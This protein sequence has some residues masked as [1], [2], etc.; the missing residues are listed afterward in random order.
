MV[1]LFV[2][3]ALPAQPGQAEI[4]QVQRLIELGEID[5]ALET[6]EGYIAEYPREPKM[7]FLKGLIYTTKLQWQDAIDVFRSLS[8]DFPD[9]PAPLNNLAV[10]Y[11][12]IGNYELALDALKEALQINPDYASAHENLGDI[13]VTL[14]ALSYRKATLHKEKQQTARAKL[15]V[16]GQ[17]IPDLTDG[18]GPARADTETTPQLA[19]VGSQPHVDPDQAQEIDAMIRSWA[20]AW[21]SQD[22]D[23]YLGF[24]SDKFQPEGGES[25]SRWRSDRRLRLTAPEYI[26]VEILKV[27]P[28]SI[29]SRRTRATIVQRYESNTYQGTALKDLVL[30]REGNQWRIVQE[31][32]RR[33]Q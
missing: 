3:P 17:L 12:E 28:R 6:A 11:A 13:Y 26:R 16:L 15:K 33:E 24:Y 22:V 2:P 10:A 9:L 7:R 5:R 4:D 29:D 18:P 8:N 30:E 32:V 20:S 23:S 1:T 31:L 25:L 14:A 27:E 21:S 19:S